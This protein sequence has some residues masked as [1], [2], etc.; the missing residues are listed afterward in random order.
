MVETMVLTKPNKD[1]FNRLA[2]HQFHFE[3]SRYIKLEKHKL[4]QIAD[5]KNRISLDKLVYSF[6]EV[7][8]ERLWKK[9]ARAN[10]D[11]VTNCYGESW[12]SFHEKIMSPS[13]KPMSP[14]PKAS[15]S[16]NIKGAQTL[17]ESWNEVIIFNSKA[18][19]GVLKLK[20]S[21]SILKHHK[22]LKEKCSFNNNL[23][24]TSCS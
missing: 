21:L 22:R 17:T 18:V 9:G 1:T 13:P 20:Y 16:H 23:F 11:F 10:S 19:Y 6:L 2:R 4:D 7:K 24:N 14:C 8:L 15:E 12:D 5:R 3:S